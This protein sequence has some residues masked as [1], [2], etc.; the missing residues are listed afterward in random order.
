[1]PDVWIAC[2]THKPTSVGSNSD[3]QIMSFATSTR[4]LYDL[5]ESALLL[6]DENPFIEQNVLDGFIGKV[7]DH[8]YLSKGLRLSG[9][10]FFHLVNG[11]ICFRYRLCATEAGPL[12]STQAT[13]K[14]PF[15]LENRWR[16]IFPTFPTIAY[17]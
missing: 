17:H 1:M 4:C 11:F 3:S 8:C 7:Q 6:H 12:L 2:C 10:L 16:N 14:N 5:L 9:N 13:D 15:S